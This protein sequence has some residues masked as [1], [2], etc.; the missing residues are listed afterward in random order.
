MPSFAKFTAVVLDKEDFRRENSII[1]T[2][3]LFLPRHLG[4]DKFLPKLQLNVKRFTN[5]TSRFWLKKS[6]KRI[7]RSKTSEHTMPHRDIQRKEN[8]V[9]MRKHFFVGLYVDDDAIK[10]NL[11]SNSGQYF[12]WQISLK[13]NYHV[14]LS[15]KIHHFH[16]F[17]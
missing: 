3:K 15:K 10:M 17:F 1:T 4:N 9:K 2:T 5:D 11:F 14:T 6:L 8:R 16:F 12:C 7:E 13:R